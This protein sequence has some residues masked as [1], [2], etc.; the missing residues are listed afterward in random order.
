MRT[1]R[2]KRKKTKEKKREGDEEKETRI[3]NREGRSLVYTYHFWLST[4]IRG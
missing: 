2:A 4:I 3:V 1:K